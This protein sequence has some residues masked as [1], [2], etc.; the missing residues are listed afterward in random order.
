MLYQ[1]EL[2]AATGQPYAPDLLIG[3]AAIGVAVVAPEILR[4]VWITQRLPDGPLRD[5]LVTLA[6]Q[7]RLRYREILVWHSGG[8][9]VNAAVTGII[10]PLRYVMITD[11]MLEQMEDAKIEAVFGHEAGHVKRHHIF[12]FLLFALISGCAV[13]IFSLRTYKLATS[14]P[15]LHQLVATLGGVALLLKWGVFFGWISRRFER[16]ADV[17]GVRAL[18]VGGLPCAQPCMLHTHDSPAPVGGVQP[19]S[20]A[21]PLCSTA[22][23]VFAH[24]LNDVALLNGIRPNARS[25]RHSSIS[26]RARFL[27]ELA[28]DPVRSARFDRR[29]LL[30]KIVIF[31]VALVVSVWAAHELHV[32]EALYKLVIS[33]F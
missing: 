15:G 22:A 14:D 10:A 12:F 16:Q 8:L 5:R 31:A 17:F 26:S 27:Q 20:P 3:L 7:L 33:W 29:L 4:H 23:H 21:A 32:W 30:I 9:I 11:G 28:G 2:R 1:A 18:T 19:L 13:T 6:R 24:A 25:W